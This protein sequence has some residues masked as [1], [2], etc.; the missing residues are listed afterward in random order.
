[1]ARDRRPSSLDNKRCWQ[2]RRCQPTPGH[3]EAA[4]LSSAT[5]RSSLSL[6]LSSFSLSLW[7][8]DPEKGGVLPLC[9]LHNRPT[10]AGQPLDPDRVDARFA[11]KDPVYVTRPDVTKGGWEK[12]RCP[13]DRYC[14][15]SSNWPIGRVLKPCVRTREEA[16]DCGTRKR[17]MRG[18]KGGWTQKYV[19]G[20][21]GKWN[22]AV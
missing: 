1:M 6:F 7:S 21:T 2:R 15:T 17:W 16:E 9:R 12:K 19:P 20:G 22:A 3:R 14:R 11:R 13:A 4:S 10:P 8:F 5:P 18:H